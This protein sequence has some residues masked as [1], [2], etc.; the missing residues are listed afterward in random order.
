M[1]SNRITRDQA[2]A[3]LHAI[4]YGISLDE[5][6]DSRAWWETSAGVAFGERKLAELEALVCDL[7]EISTQSFESDEQLM[8]DGPN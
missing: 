4:T 5:G 2:L 8:G 3:A 6:C 7:T 1:S